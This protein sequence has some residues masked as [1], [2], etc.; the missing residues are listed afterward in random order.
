MCKRHL[1]PRKGTNMTMMIRGADG[2]VYNSTGELAASNVS[3]NTT[4]EA[5]RVEGGHEDHLSGAFEY[6]G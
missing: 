4:T 6:L 5:V 2:R 3:E 1:P